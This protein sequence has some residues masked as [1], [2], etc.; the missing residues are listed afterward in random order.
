MSI[1]EKMASNQKQIWEVIFY[2][3]GN[4]YSY[5][6]ISTKYWQTI[7]KNFLKKTKLNKYFLIEL[8][9]CF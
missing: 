2:S 6:W 4:E 5:I 8:S 7:I 1:A 3:E 9:V